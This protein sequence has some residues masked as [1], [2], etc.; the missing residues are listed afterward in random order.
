MPCRVA[1][2]VSLER[3]SISIFNISVAG[4]YRTFHGLTDAHC[5]DANANHAIE[6][7]FACGL[8]ENCDP[9]ANTIAPSSEGLSAGMNVG[10]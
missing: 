1:R 7:D 5:L 6:C 8:S 9:I 10:L 4:F 3:E 2:S